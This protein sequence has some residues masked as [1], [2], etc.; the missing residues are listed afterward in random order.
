MVRK[1]IQ[2]KPDKLQKQEFKS[3]NLNIQ[4]QSKI[5]K[6]HS[7]KHQKER[8]LQNKAIYESFC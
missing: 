6:E 1:V 8:N 7:M 2:L 3:R 4:L 5:M